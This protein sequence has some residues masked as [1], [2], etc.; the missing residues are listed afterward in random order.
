MKQYPLRNPASSFR[1]WNEDGILF[2]YKNKKLLTLNSVAAK[3]IQLSDGKT[4]LEN[5]IQ[6]IA[7]EFN[8]DSSIVM[9]DTSDFFREMMVKDLLRLS[10]KKVEHGWKELLEA[11]KNIEP[12]SKES[13]VSAGVNVS[14][15]KGGG[16]LLK[17]LTHD[18]EQLLIPLQVILELTY[19]CNLN[20]KHCYIENKIPNDLLKKEYFKLLDELAEMGTLEI[21]FTGGEPFLRKDFFHILEYARLLGFSCIIKTSG[22]LITEEN[23]ETLAELFPHE[24]HVSLYSMNPEEHDFITNTPGSFKKSKRII[25]LLAKRGIQVK[26]SSALMKNTFHS[27]PLLLDFAGKVGARIIFDLILVPGREGSS[28]PLQLAA[29]DAELKEIFS[30]PELTSIIM[31]D[32]RYTSGNLELKTS[33]DTGDYMCGAGVVVAA[34]SPE[35]NVS[36]CTGMGLKLG[37]IKETSFKK[38]WHDSENIKMLRGIK[39]IELKTCMKCFKKEFCT[40]CPGI[41]LQEKGSLT[42]ISPSSCLIAGYAIRKAGDQKR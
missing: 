12:Y 11:W 40:R 14:S 41:A 21:V 25:E 26:I 27:A 32:D 34:V 4:T 24:V 2:D 15:A 22:T 28:T 18:A 5:I 8:I 37:N 6:E 17:K 20:C 10:D 31:G 30:N 29:G 9:A 36:P 7:G 3:I 23:I 19:R 13:P 35:G 38:I 39:N 42:E 33:W 1:M 16:E